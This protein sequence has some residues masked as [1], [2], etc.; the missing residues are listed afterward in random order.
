MRLAP[1]T[2]PQLPRRRGRRGHAMRLCCLG[3]VLTILLTG[4]YA[5]A[6][7][8]QIP[9]RIGQNVKQQLANR[10]KQSED[11]LISQ[12]ASQTD[13]L[14]A[15]GAKP[16]DDMIAKTIEGVDA[17]MVKSYHALVGSESEMDRELREALDQGRVDLDLGFAAQG[18]SLS[19]DGE[20]MINALARVL[21]KSQGDFIIEGRY[22]KGEDKALGRKRGLGVMVRLSELDV[23]TDQLHLVPHSGVSPDRS[24]GVIP[25]R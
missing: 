11:S 18:T 14:I 2:A 17:M 25:V 9:S 5:E 16:I 15:Q 22:V 10:K 8:A 19:P 21:R 1:H 23:D 7:V 3:G 6:A 12:V 4:S 24:L 13:S 20:T